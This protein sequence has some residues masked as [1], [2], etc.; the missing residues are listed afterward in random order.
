MV[1]DIRRGYI[2]VPE[3]E[4]GVGRGVGVVGVG[5]V[6]APSPD[7]QGFQKFSQMSGVH[8]AQS[9]AVL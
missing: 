8:V 6:H 7:A 1:P 5:V 3:K 4:K 9:L 2:N